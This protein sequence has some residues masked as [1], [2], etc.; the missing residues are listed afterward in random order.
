VRR[1][2]VLALVLKNLVQP[3]V[4]YAVGRWVLGLHGAELLAPTLLAALPT[5]QNVYV[6]AVHYR[7]SRTLARSA[8]LLSTLV[9]IPIMTLIAGLLS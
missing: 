9:S 3:L 1:D 8:V 4:G 6:Y 7:S 5:A 2:V